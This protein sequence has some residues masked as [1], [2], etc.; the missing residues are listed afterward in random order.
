MKH[1]DFR[2]S[3]HL[4]AAV[5]VQKIVSVF[6]AAVGQ[7]GSG[8]KMGIKTNTG[9]GFSAVK[10]YARSCKLEQPRPADDALGQAG[11]I[12]IRRGCPHSQQ[13]SARRIGG[14]RFAHAL[15]GVWRIPAII[16][17]KNYDVCP[18]VFQQNIPGHGNPFR[19]QHDA[20]N[21][22][23][24]M[25]RQHIVQI[26]RRILISQKNTKILVGLLLERCKQPIK[27]PLTA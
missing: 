13:C 2:I 12:D 24:G 26:T 1:P 15:K 23:A 25:A 16:I 18:G 3:A 4:C 9:Y 6:A 14:K 10:L 11:C 19:G 27:L 8:P 7:A 5:C 17:G 22:Q 21:G 20:S